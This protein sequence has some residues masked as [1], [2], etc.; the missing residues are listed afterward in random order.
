[1]AEKQDG[2][3]REEQ[4]RDYRTIGAEGTGAYAEKKSRFLARALHVSCE[5]E[6]SVALAE[7]KKRYYD[8]KHHCSAWI[9][10]T[11]GAPRTERAS[12]DGEPSGT[13]GNPMLELLKGNDLT[14]CMVIV[15]RYFGGTLLGTG[16]LMR[17]YTAAAKAALAQAQIVRMCACDVLGLRIGYRQLDRILFWLSRER[18]SFE[19]PVYAEQI[20]LRLTVPCAETEKRR[21]ELEELTAGKAEI[22]VEESGFF[23]IDNEFS[24]G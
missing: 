12:D 5:E 22:A 2:A 24:V 6:V 23:S 16:G 8:A 4:R 17:A 15:T 19:E 3:L 13:A 1:M 7:E 14:D 11:G 21:R 10:G 20:S 18:L 9:T